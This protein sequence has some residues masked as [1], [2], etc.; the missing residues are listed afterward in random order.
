MN[1]LVCFHPLSCKNKGGIVPFYLHHTMLSLFIEH[2]CVRNLPC[3]NLIKYRKQAG[4]NYSSNKRMEE[5]L[6]PKE[7]RY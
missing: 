2:K 5:D 7:L 3:K 4:G 1:T 6:L